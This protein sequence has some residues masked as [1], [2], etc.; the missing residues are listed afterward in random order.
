MQLK[1]Q[2]FGAGPA[3]TIPRMAEHRKPP[4]LEIDYEGWD[5]PRNGELISEGP[6]PVYMAVDMPTINAACKFIREMHAYTPPL[7]SGD[8][9]DLETDTLSAYA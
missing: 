4:V 6:P 7:T 1:E 8:A 5:G 9:N 2:L 3:I